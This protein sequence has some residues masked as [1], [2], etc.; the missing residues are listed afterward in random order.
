[1][2]ATLGRGNTVRPKEYQRI[3]SSPVIKKDFSFF[4]I[5]VMTPNEFLTKY[6]Y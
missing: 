2:N 5:P 3:A 1:M 4:D 6:A